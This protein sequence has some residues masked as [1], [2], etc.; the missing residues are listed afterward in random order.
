MPQPVADDIQCALR[1]DDSFSIL[2]K[3]AV[4][5]HAILPACRVVG[6]K[7]DDGILPMKTVGT[8]GHGTGFFLTPGKVHAVAALR[9]GEVHVKCRA[10]LL[11][12]EEGIMNAFLIFFIEK[13]LF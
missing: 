3:N 9:L 1:I 8:E 12:A 2:E 10:K 7:G 6:G 11:V 5:V 4:A 13:V